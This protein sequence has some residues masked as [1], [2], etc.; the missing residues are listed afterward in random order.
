[1]DDFTSLRVLDRFKW[2]F[3]KLHIDY[4]MMRKILQL[5]LTMDGRRMPTVFNGSKVKK[6]GN[7]FLKSLWMY[8]LYG[9]ITTDA[10]FIFRRSI[11]FFYEYYV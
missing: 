7:Q 11:Y 9:V 2:I 10:I 8:G 1:M 3:Q 5:K 4:E 6:E